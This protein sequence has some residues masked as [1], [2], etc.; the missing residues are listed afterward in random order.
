MI[1]VTG[2]LTASNADILAGT[3]LNA[4]PFDGEL[5]LEV[6]GDAQSAPQ[7]N[8]AKMTIQIPDGAVPMQDMRIPHARVGKGTLNDDD[9]SAFTFDATQGGHFDIEIDISGT[10]G[11]FYRVTLS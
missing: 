7:T 8:F 2:Y 3:R 11:V 10:H 6:L 9:E 5:L 4:I 1:I